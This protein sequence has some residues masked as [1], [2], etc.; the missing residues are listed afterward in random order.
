MEPIAPVEITTVVP[1]E[2]GSR[3]WREGMK[4]MPMILEDVSN[5]VWRKRGKAEF[6]KR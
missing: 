1:I 4:L 3:N 2:T 5:R 6:E